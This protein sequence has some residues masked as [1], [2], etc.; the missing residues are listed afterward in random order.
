MYPFLR[1]AKELIRH[2]SAPPLPLTGTHV[3]RLTCWPWDIDMWGE[4]N[5]GRSLTLYDLGRVPLAV[6]TG[7]ARALRARR[8]GLTMAG[9]VVRWRRRVHSFETVEMH[10]RCLGWDARFLYIEQSMWKADGSCASHA[11]YRAAITGPR[12]IVPPAEVARAMGHAPLSPPLP[13]WVARWSALEADRPWP[14]RRD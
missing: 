9:A 1:M 10:S 13:D 2:R 7:L 8:W 6:R 14:P 5:N 12:G 11:I 3:T 4:L